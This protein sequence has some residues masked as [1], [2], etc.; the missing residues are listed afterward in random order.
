MSAQ[1][2]VEEPL[3]EPEIQ[4]EAII[5]QEKEQVE[6]LVESPLS[7]KPKRKPKPTQVYEIF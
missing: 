5:N 1:K 3:K 7:Y 6:E 2:V 4:P